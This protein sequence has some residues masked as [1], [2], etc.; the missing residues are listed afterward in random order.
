MGAVGDFPTLFVCERGWR[1]EKSVMP[2]KS[3]P[4]HSYWSSTENNTNN[5][6]NVRFSDGNQNNNNKNNA[7]FARC[8]R[9][10]SL[11]FTFYA[12]PT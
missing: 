8:V 5:A 7:N 9:S 2:A 10:R 1:I 12:R 6:W 4:S 11:S 3:R